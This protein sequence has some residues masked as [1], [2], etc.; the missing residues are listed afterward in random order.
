[1]CDYI[2]DVILCVEN[3]V[4]VHICCLHHFFLRIRHISGVFFPIGS[5]VKI[6]RELLCWLN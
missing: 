3:K 6:G 4:T 2:Y 5:L 1:M